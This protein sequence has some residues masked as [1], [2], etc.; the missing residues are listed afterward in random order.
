MSINTVTLSGNIGSDPELKSTRSGGS[1]LKFRMA[2]RSGFGE[3]EKAVWVNASIL[4]TKY[5]EAMADVLKKGMAV[6]VCGELQI[7]D[8]E[9]RDGNK[10]TSVE[11]IVRDMVAPGAGKAPSSQHEE[12]KRDGYAPPDDDVPF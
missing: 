1:I 2:G 11:V 7:D 12:R 3:G 9:D 4:K 6:T 10:R 8:W 5:A